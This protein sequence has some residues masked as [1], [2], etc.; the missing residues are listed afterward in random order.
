M[1]RV[2]G[3]SGGGG[4][5]HY[6]LWERSHVCYW[7]QRRSVKAKGELKRPGRLNQPA[8]SVT[9]SPEQ[10]PRAWN[11]WACGGAGACV[12]GKH[13]SVGW[14]AFGL[15]VCLCVC[16]CLSIIPRCDVCGETEF[17]SK[18]PCVP[19]CTIQQCV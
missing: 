10:T 1:R 19:A 2:G 3:G 15:C 17:H 16:V 8:F 13:E 5:V 6:V 4:V 14:Q 11:L 12:E 18:W 9:D 7:S